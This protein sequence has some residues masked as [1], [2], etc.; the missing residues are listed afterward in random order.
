MHYDRIVGCHSNA[1]CFLENKNG[2]NN[3]AS[4]PSA[5]AQ[6]HY[7]GEKYGKNVRFCQINVSAVCRRRKQTQHYLVTMEIID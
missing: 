5:L 4:F 6:P 3:L 1:C 2:S 7:L